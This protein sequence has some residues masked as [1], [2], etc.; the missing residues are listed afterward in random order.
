MSLAKISQ[1]LFH[2]LSRSSIMFGRSSRR[3]PVSIQSFS[4]YVLA[5]R[6]TPARPYDWV[7]RRMSLI[8]SSLHL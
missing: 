8:I 6:S 5:G 7:H 2:H 4:R 1:T 3:Y